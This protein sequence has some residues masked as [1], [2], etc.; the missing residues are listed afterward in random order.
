[1]VLLDDDKDSEASYDDFM[2]SA[3]A[4]SAVEAAS[5]A[6]KKNSAPHT[7]MNSV[8]ESVGIQDLTEMQA[9]QLFFDVY[10]F[11]RVR[12]RAF[13]AAAEASQKR[14]FTKLVSLK[15][16]FYRHLL[17]LMRTSGTTKKEATFSTELLLKMV[18]MKRQGKKLRRLYA[19]F[20]RKED[21]AILSSSRTK[22]QKGVF[23]LF[24]CAVGLLSSDDTTS[25]TR[26][27][28]AWKGAAISHL[29]KFCRS[30]VCDDSTHVH[31][32]ASCILRCV[33]YGE[34]EEEEEEERKRIII[35]STRLG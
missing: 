17:K 20:M 27:T 35:L 31:S 26:I 10:L 22:M 24:V 28:D 8:I 23:G 13:E 7:K 3:I 6:S 5:C 21:E 25:N 30:R 29:L 1:M 14:F 9:R 2:E 32:L 12:R 19:F 34:E 11:G 15:R 16:C 4:Q 18:I 33:I